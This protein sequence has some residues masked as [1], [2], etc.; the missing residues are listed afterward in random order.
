MF[1]IFNKFVYIFINMKCGDT[2]TARAVPLRETRHRYHV[3]T[4]APALAAR[5]CALWGQPSCTYMYHYSTV[6]RYEKQW[7][8]GRQRKVTVESAATRSQTALKQYV[9]RVNLQARTALSRLK[10]QL[11]FNVALVN[12]LLS[13]QKCQSFVLN[14]EPRSVTENLQAQR[15]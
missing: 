4:P 12:L 15:R 13:N 1:L 7:R 5:A 2:S 9:R 8:I 3:M 6:C 14:V 10:E 11:H